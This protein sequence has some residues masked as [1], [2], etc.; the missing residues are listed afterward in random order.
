MFSPNPTTGTNA[1]SGRTTPFS[2]ATS[3]KTTPTAAALSATSEISGRITPA[4][5]LRTNSLEVVNVEELM[6]EVMGACNSGRE[7]GAAAY[8]AGEHVA[9]TPIYHEV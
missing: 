5:I 4:A 6:G 7:K 2:L 3:G 9:L 8:A 1:N